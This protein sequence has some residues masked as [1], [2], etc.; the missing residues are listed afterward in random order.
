MRFYRLWLALNTAK[1]PT[2]WSEFSGRPLYWV[3]VSTYVQVLAVGSC[4]TAPMKSCQGLPHARHGSSEF[5]PGPVV[6]PQ[7]R[8]EPVS[9]TGGTFGKTYLRKIKNT[10][11]AMRSQRGWK[12]RVRNSSVGSRV[13][14]EGDERGASCARV[15]LADYGE[16]TVEQIFPCS[17]YRSPH[18]SRITL[19]D[20]SLWRGAMLEQGESLRMRCYGLIIIPYSSPPLCFFRSDKIEDWGEKELS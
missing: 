3:P 18:W 20:C 19:K 12:K 17:P 15:A 7:D 2:N 8:A 10:L 16:T 14:E 13:R 9:Q 6:P 5:Q 4:R 11:Q 1:A